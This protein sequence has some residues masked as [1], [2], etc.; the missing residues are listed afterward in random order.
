MKNRN[1]KTN[2]G[3][4]EWLLRLT[5]FLLALALFAG[6]SVL[7]GGAAPTEEELQKQM[8]DAE[9]RIQQRQKEIEELRKEKKEQEKLIPVLEAQVKEIDGKASLIDREIQALNS[10]VRQLR[11]RIEALGQQIEECKA[12][13]LRIQAETEDKRVTIGDMQE[14]LKERLR[15]QYMAG[16]VSNLQLLLSSP[17]LTS[18][19]TVAEYIRTQADRDAVLRRQLEAEMADLMRLEKEREAEQANLEVRR[20]ELETENDALEMQLQEQRRAKRDLDAQ[21]ERISEAQSEL[22]GIINSLEKQTAD[23]RR[24]LEADRKAMQEFEEKLDALLQEKKQSG[25]INADGLPIVEGQ[26]T[27]PVPT[28]KCYISSPYGATS[29]R[30]YPHE[31]LDISATNANNSDYPI[32]AAL[33]GVVLDYGWTNSRGNYVVLY[34]GYYAPKGKEIKTTYMHLR[35]IDGCITD[36]AKIKAGKVIGIMGSTGNSTGAHLHFQINEIASDG[37]SKS[38]DPLKYVSNPY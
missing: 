26:M 29:N 20:G 19:L 10:S 6:A 9:D 38:V 1:L 22:Y 25:A 30:A 23:A 24:L 7:P 15:Q 12:T 17:D 21:R 16:P 37:T 18:F 11:G 13:I 31:G 35:S 32:I 27:W 3:F 33:D 5:A 4:R 36:G 34:H 14:R 28:S 8:A 2:K